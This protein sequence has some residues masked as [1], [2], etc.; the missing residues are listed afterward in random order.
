MKR[1]RGN[2]ETWPRAK[3]LADQGCWLTEAARILKIHH[4]TAIY[5]SR[6]MGFKWGQ[7]PPRRP[8]H[9]PES[10]APIKFRNVWKAK[11][12][13]REWIV[14]DEAVDRI[15]RMMALAGRVA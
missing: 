2:R 3:E 4:T 14:S 1:G 9:K 5:I 12:V 13:E 10:F 6:Q 7:C 8:E 15:E 11:P